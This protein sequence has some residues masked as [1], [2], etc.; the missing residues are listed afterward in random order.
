MAGVLL[1]RGPASED[2]DRW[3]L[4]DRDED[5]LAS[6]WGPLVSHAVDPADESRAAIAHERG[7][8]IVSAWDQAGALRLAQAL[9]P[10]Y[11][12]LSEA[13][14]ERHRRGGEGRGA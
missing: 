11:A 5:N 10:A 4:D 14:L 2:A 1:L 12:E 3:P 9:P 6:T 7:G 8:T 13:I